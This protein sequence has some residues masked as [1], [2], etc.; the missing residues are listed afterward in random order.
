MCSYT[1]IDKIYHGYRALFFYATCF[2][3]L[4]ILDDA[5]SLTD[6]SLNLGKWLNGTPLLI[7]LASLKSQEKIRC[8]EGAD[9]GKKEPA[10]KVAKYTLDVMKVHPLVWTPWRAVV[11]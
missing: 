10:E 2:S 9:S 1:S 11:S 3:T 5:R 8:S 7:V 4:V 6:I